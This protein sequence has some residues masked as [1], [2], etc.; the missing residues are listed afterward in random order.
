MKQHTKALA[1]L[2]G[3]QTKK[4]A[5]NTYARREVNGAVAIRYHGTDIVT[6]DPSG[7][8]RVTNGGWKTSSTKERINWLLGLLGIK[9]GISQRA[10]SWYWSKYL[11]NAKHSKPIPFADCLAFSPNGGR[12]E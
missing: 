12:G 9:W 2:N 11:G 1:L 10:F 4:L 7:V 8:V 6:V 5:P 3:R